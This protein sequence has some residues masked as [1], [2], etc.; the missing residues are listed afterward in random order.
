LKDKEENNMARVFADR[1]RYQK[2]NPK[3][4]LPWTINDVPEK[5]RAEVQRILDEE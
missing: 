4:N 2:I 3:T 5:Y 1:I